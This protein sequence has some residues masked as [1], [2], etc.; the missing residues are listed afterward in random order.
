MRSLLPNKAVVY[1]ETDDLAKTL[2]SLTDSRAF[3]ELA[4]K[5]PDFSAL[6]N[7]QLAVAV[8]G[9]ETSAENSV[10]NFKPQFVAV[11]ETHAWSWQTL[12]FA[13]TRLDNFVRK[14]YGESTKLET[15]AKDGGKFF[16]WRASDNRQV[17]AFVKGSL[18][19]FGTDAAMIEQCPAIKK[20]NDSLMK[21]ESLSRVYSKNNLAFGY[22]SAEGLKEIA[23]FAGVN[24][25]VKTTEESAEQSFIARI[26]PQI[27]QNTT[28]EIV[29]TANK[30]GSGIEDKFSVS[31]TT[32]VAAVAQVALT[33]A[34]SLPGGTLEFLPPDFFSATRYNL[35][36]PLAAWRGL[37]L[38]TAK[39]TDAVSGRVLMEFSDRLLEPYEISGAE[40]FL[41]A[42]DSEIITIQF[43]AEGEKSV[44]I[45]TVNDPE[46][47][48]N[49]LSKEIDFKLKSANQVNA[50][51]WFSKDKQ[52]AAAFVENKL[53]LGN[54]ES[55]LRCL[56]AKHGGFNLAR[57]SMSNKFAA[58]RSAAI[59]FGKDLDSAEKIVEVLA[60]KRY[61]DQKLATF[62]STETQI[63]EKG[64]ERKTVSDF[65]LIGSI[66]K[67]L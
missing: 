1:L 54:T 25:A 65:G 57:N 15:S 29:W 8:T 14:N 49:S 34:E 6:E 23:D 27:L 2:G 16:N 42:I 35:L 26:L 19:Y 40:K 62:Y 43:D 38:L 67:Q 60:K 47:L 66:L 7:M 52:V 36:D 58:T 13:E 20:G 31:L 63:T 30:T 53:I 12:S 28:R 48:K 45:V 50:E 9:F 64:F 11:A 46:R 44:T 55:V 22:V 39:N 18:I 59:T 21:N 10:L 3:Q 61:S 33:P 51:I 4:D 5:K 24:V 37:L 17:F 56:E 41:G 32:E